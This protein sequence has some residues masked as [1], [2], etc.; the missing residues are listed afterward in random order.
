MKELLKLAEPNERTHLRDQ[1]VACMAEI[2]KFYKLAETNNGWLEDEDLEAFRALALSIEYR[3]TDWGSDIYGLEPN[4]ARVI[5]C[6][7]GP[8]VEVLYQISGYSTPDDCALVGYW[9]GDRFDLDLSAEQTEALEWAF[10]MW[11]VYTY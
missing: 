10:D 6:S 2:R 1:A 9:W 7:G 5:L 8:H 11:G 3:A 4:E